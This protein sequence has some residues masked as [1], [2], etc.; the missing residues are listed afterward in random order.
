MELNFTKE[1]NGNWF[2]EFTATKDYNLHIEVAEESER[3]VRILQKGSSDENYALAHEHFP[4]K[5]L[6]ESETFD[7]D[8]QHGIYPKLIKVE[9][10]SQPTKAT[11]NM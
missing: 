8:F 9:C 3:G 1:E 6:Q 7:M 11:L 10:V 5:A 2:A 4:A